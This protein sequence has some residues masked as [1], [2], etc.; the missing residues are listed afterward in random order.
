MSRISNVI[1]SAA[2]LIAIAV[3]AAGAQSAISVGKIPPSASSTLVGVPVLLLSA[4]ASASSTLNLT[5]R[6]GG[7]ALFQSDYDDY[8]I[9]LIG[10]VPSNNNTQLQVRVTTNGGSTWLSGAS[11]YR[12]D[13]MA[14]RG[15]I[16]P[17]LTGATTTLMALYYVGQGNAT[18]NGATAVLQLSNPAS[19]AL[20]KNLSGTVVARDAA[21]FLVTEFAGRVN[22]TTAINGIQFF[23]SAGT[24]ASGR[25]SVSARP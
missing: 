12:W 13:Q 7:G 5:S 1:A 3:L 4:T 23:Y 10:L 22:T 15:G 9:R 8:E 18:T 21:D 11:D 24:I 14:W 6:T 17:L 19:T 20:H 2:L 16:S 25:V